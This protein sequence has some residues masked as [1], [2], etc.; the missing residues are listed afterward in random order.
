MFLKLQGEGLSYAERNKF[1]KSSF[2][3][4]RESGYKV[5]SNKDL[6]ILFENPTELG[7][8]KYFSKLL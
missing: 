1:S 4:F 3:T 7:I 5:M 2:G 6:K 8:K